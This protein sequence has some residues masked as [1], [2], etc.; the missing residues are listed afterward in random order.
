MRTRQ[1]IIAETLRAYE[2]TT[3]GPDAYSPIIQAELEKR[4]T[5]EVYLTCDDFA[6]FGVACCDAAC[7]SEPHYELID[8]V[9]DDDRHAW[10]CCHIR[11]ILIRRT[12]KPQP[13]DPETK[14]KLRLWGEIFNWQPDPVAE[15]IHAANMAATSDRDKLY[16]CLKYGH[17]KW[18]R[19]RGSESLGAIVQRALSQPGSLPAKRCNESDPPP[20]CGLCVQCAC[21]IFRENFIPGSNSHNCRRCRKLPSQ[22]M[23]SMEQQKQEEIEPMTPE[24]IEAEAAYA[25]EIYERLSNPT[26]EETRKIFESIERHKRSKAAALNHKKSNLFKSEM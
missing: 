23:S 24:Q 14:E 19:R 10:V 15:E 9:L 3:G 22:R 18:G 6:H 26:P 4:L 20:S 12:E 11:D 8:V 21:L 16:Y 25:K 13:D 7:E 17:Y 1:Q 5:E 2:A